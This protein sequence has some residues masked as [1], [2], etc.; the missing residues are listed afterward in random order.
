MLGACRTVVAGIALAAGG[1]LLI[2][3]T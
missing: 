2:I 1:G 3:A